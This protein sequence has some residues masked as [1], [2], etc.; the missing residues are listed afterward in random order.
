MLKR[1]HDYPV[2]VETL[3]RFVGDF[4]TFP[5]Y[6]PGVSNLAEDELPIGS[7]GKTYCET[8]DR[9]VFKVHVYLKVVRWEQNRL[10]EVESSLSP[11]KP[12]IRFEFEPLGDRASRMV[13]I[14]SARNES[15]PI[16]WVAAPI[17]RRTLDVILPKALA[18]LAERVAAA[19]GKL[20]AV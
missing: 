2:P 11:I 13:W 16:R 15:A 14:S 9:I 18:T 8:I 20:R 3:F 1:E 12:H 5:T 7:I 10:I 6:F 4:M 17:M 19:E